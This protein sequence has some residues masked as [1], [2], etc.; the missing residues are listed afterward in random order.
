MHAGLAVRSTPS[1]VVAVQVDA[2]GFSAPGTGFQVALS[3]DGPYALG[4]TEVQLSVSSQEGQSSCSALLTVQ[5][6]VGLYAI[7]RLCPWCKAQ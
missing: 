6:C 7:G 2:A 5:V 1:H 3:P 4:K